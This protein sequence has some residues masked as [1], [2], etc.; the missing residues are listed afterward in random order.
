MKVWWHVFRRAGP[1]PFAEHDVQRRVGERVPDFP[2]LQASTVAFIHLLA[3][4]I[5]E[6][7][8]IFIADAEMTTD[9]GKRG[10]AP[11][12]LVLPSGAWRKQEAAVEDVMN[13]DLPT[14]GNVNPSRYWNCV[15][16]TWL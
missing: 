8:C 13:R 5:E 14:R 11:W 12:R 2:A 6:D 1:G 7:P 3:P 10:L 15:C 4:N 16:S 9:H